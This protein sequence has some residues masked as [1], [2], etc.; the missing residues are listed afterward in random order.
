M[1]A[2]YAY[3]YM[4]ACV[5]VCLF[6]CVYARALSVRMRVCACVCMCVFIHA[7]V[8]ATMECATHAAWQ[9]WGSAVAVAVAGQ[10]YGAF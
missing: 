10:Q 2:M 6:V 9:Y 1:Y 7:R 5:G 3:A 8:P 4:Y